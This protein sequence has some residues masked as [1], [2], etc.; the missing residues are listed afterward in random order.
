VPNLYNL[1]VLSVPLKR[2]KF[3]AICWATCDYFAGAEIAIEMGAFIFEI[4]WRTQWRKMLTV[5]Q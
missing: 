4:N 2:V 3:E 1:P 5:L